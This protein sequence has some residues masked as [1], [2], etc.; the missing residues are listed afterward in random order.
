MSGAS[1]KI[2]KHLHKHET[3]IAPE[4]VLIWA[5]DDFKRNTKERISSKIPV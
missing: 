5:N 3:D 2:S 1:E 4:K